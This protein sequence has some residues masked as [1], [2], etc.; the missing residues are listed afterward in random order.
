ML[1]A[2]VWKSVVFVAVAGAGGYWLGMTAWFVAGALAGLLA[3]HLR[4][5]IHLAEWARLDKRFEPP[6]AGGLWGDVYY[7]IYRLERRNKKRKK[8]L[9]A[10]LGRFQL[11]TEALPYGTL[12][13]G[14][15]G[16]I[17][18]MNPAAARLSGL[19]RRQDKNRRITNLLRHPD[20]VQY[21]AAADYSEP[22]EIP[23]PLADGVRLSLHAVPFGKKQLLI[24]IQDITREKQIE[25]MR[26][27]FVANVSH[28]LRTPLT[29]LMGYLE[30]FGEHPAVISDE[31]DRHTV[32]QMQEQSERMRHIV[33]DL[34]LLSKLETSGVSEGDHG[35]VPVPGVLSDI[36]T[37]AGMMGQG[38]VI[39]THVDD[40]LWLHGH[41]AE[42]HSAFSNLV[43]NA[44]RYSPSGGEIRL[45]WYRD[46]EGAHFSVQDQGIGMEPQH[47][48]RLTERFY[49]VDKDRSRTSGGTGLGLAIVKHVLQR[50]G[51]TLRIE[52]EPGEGSTFICDFPAERIVHKP[53]QPEVIN[54]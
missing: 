14:P 47:I 28:E 3:G 44:I 16:E 46:A 2:E 27:E 22:V 26:K 43:S 10:M 12:I 25:T 23:S 52:S 7:G 13:A 9:A 8:K 45:D 15:H 35:P 6:D 36:E 17:Q 20:F 32:Q 34:L 51:A 37:D 39:T 33:E 11:A 38:H 30:A 21:L 1:R 48:P 31:Q 18:W 29:V 40:A 53:D 54:A 41:T 49:R 5:L 24:T 19:N 4:H 42:L 50:H